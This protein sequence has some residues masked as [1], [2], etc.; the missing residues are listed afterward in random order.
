MNERNLFHT[1]AIA[2]G[3]VVRTP[4]GRRAVVIAVNDARGEAT[5][6]TEPERIDFR[7]SKLVFLSCGTPAEAGGEP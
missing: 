3:C 7:T 2:P 1:Q 4:A 6:Q 5:V